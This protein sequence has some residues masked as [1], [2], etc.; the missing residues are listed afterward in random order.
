MVGVAGAFLIFPVPILGRSLLG[1]WWVGDPDHSSVGKRQ[2]RMFQVRVDVAPARVIALSFPFLFVLFVIFV[3]VHPSVPPL[4]PVLVV[5]FSFV[6]YV[7]VSVVDS[8]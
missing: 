7:D 6:V 5:P 1:S 3:P 8:Y 2:M 4:V